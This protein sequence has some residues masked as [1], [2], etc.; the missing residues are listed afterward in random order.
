MSGSKKSQH[1]VQHELG[2]A[3]EDEGAKIGH[4]GMED[5]GLVA[6]SEAR[7]GKTDQPDDAQEGVGD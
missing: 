1:E 4:R 3:A 6:Q 2:K 5:E 7:A